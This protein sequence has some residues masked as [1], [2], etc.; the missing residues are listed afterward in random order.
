M[1]ILYTEVLFLILIFYFKIIYQVQRFL[2]FLIYIDMKKYDLEILLFY[3][4]YRHTL[5]LYP[6]KV[7]FCLVSYAR[8]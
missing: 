7:I 6:S 3:E 8:S 5:T 1:M 4:K 2:L